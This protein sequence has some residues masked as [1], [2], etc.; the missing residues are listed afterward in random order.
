MK[1]KRGNNVIGLLHTEPKEKPTSY[2]PTLRRLLPAGYRLAVFQPAAATLA[3]AAATAQRRPSEAGL[4]Q[5][6]YRV[7]AG[8][9]LLVF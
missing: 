1:K 4:G 9:G 8:G 6:I 2:R 3:G 7:R 5:L